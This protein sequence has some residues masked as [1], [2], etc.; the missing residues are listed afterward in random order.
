MNPNLRAWAGSR[1]GVVLLPVLLVALCDPRPARAASYLYVSSGTALQYRRGDS[2]PPS[3]WESSGFTPGSEWTSSSAGYGIGYGDGDDATLLTDMQDQYMTVYVRTTFTVGAE[4]PSLTYLELSARYDDGFVAYLNGVEIA[5]FGVPAGQTNTTT[6]SSHE[7]TDGDAVVSLDPSLLVSGTNVFAVEV[8]NTTLGSSDLSFIP[9]LWGYDTPPPDAEITLGPYLQQVGRRSALVVWETDL[10]AASRVAYG[11]SPT[12]L[13]NHVEDLVDQT[14]HVVQVNGLVPG[15]AMYF[16]VESARIPSQ[17][18]Q[19][20]PETDAAEPYRFIIYGDTRSNHDDHALMVAAML[21]E[22]PAFTVHTGDLV[23]NGENEP[24]WA[25]FFDIEANLIR[26][27][28]LYPALGNHEADGVRYLELFEMPEDSSQSENYY[29]F[30]YA[31]TGVVT[32]DLY[33]SPYGPGSD[34]YIWLENTLAAWQDDP[35]IRLKLV[36]LHHGPYDSGPHASNTSVRND[37]VPLFETYGVQAVFAGHDHLYERSTVNGIKYVVTGGGGAPLYSTTGDWWTQYAESVLHYV[38][39]EVEGPRATVTARRMDGTVLD[40]FT[41]GATLDE[42]SA[43][44]DCASRSPGDCLPDED[45]AWVCL[46]SG[47]VW[48]CTLP[49]PEPDAG[50]TPDAG[51]PSSDAGVDAGGAVVDAGSTPPAGNE[52]CGCRAAGRSSPGAGLVLLPL[53]VWLVWRRRRGA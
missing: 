45:G 32:L 37:L 33:L 46:H 11:P 23:A 20:W 7:V 5:R 4:L 25:W 47:C 39:V 29:A 27:V 6:A 52:G 17:V 36:V 41:L 8:H 10:P 18:G 24:D 49:E 35:Q 19:I 40:Q 15:Q 42:C 44:S 34:Q 48:N 28:P 1:V 9:T 38:L 14:R 31:T 53:L 51:G 26:N 30:Q 2:P 21:A 12:D 43:A 13:P 16:R 3:Q 50:V 22:A